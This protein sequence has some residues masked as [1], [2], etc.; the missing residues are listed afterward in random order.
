M[1]RYFF[2][3]IVLFFNTTQL[4]A[5]FVS[6]PNDAFKSFLMSKYPGCFNG[7]GDLDTT[8]AAIIT[9][10]SLV[11]HGVTGINNYTAL[12]Y[13]D[14]L[15]YLD[16][17]DN[18]FSAATV[19]PAKLPETITTLIA[20]NLY[21][22]SEN[23]NISYANSFIS[24]IPA[25][26]QHFGFSKNSFSE[27]NLV[28]WSASLRYLD[29][30]FNKFNG[31]AGVL[32]IS[33][34]T[35]LCNN[36]VRA[37][38][39]TVGSMSGFTSSL[40]VALKYFDCHENSMGS[41]PSLP[42][43]LRYIDCSSQ[44]LFFGLSSNVPV[45]ALGSLPVTLPA[46]LVALKCSKNKI[47]SLPV[48]PESL[49]YLDCSSQKY[50]NVLNSITFNYPGISSLPVLPQTLNYLNCGNNPISCLPTLP[51]SMTGNSVYNT[52]TYNLDITSTNI[53]C[54]PNW[55]PGIIVNG[56]L[57]MPLCGISSP[58]IE[59]SLIKGFIFNDNNSNGVQD[60]GETAGAHIRVKLNNDTYTFSNG[61]GKYE[62]A[63]PIGNNQVTIEPPFYYNAVPPTFTH[64][65]TNN[66]TI[67][68]D[69]VALQPTTLYDSIKVSIT[70][71]NN[72]RANGLLTY[73]VNFE[74]RGT[75]TVNSTITINF[76][77]T[78]LNYN[79][80]NNG[81]VIHSGNTLTLT[82]GNLVPGQQ[83]SFNSYFT[84]SILAPFSTAIT[85]IAHAVAGTCNDT[86]SSICYVV[87]AID[88][89]D[90]QATAILSGDEVSRGFFIDYLIR[91]QNVGNASA[92]N[93]FITDTLSAALN[94]S[95]MELV[96]TSYNCNMTLTDN[97]LLC[98]FTNINLPDS[99]SSPVGSHGFVKFRI[100]P[101]ATLTSNTIIKNKASIYF[102]YNLPV[103]TN[104]ANTIIAFWPIPLTLLDFFGQVDPLNNV[105]LTWKTAE[106]NNVSHFEIE[107]STDGRNFRY[108]ASEQAIGTGSNMYR[109]SLKLSAPVV[110]YRLKMV[111][112][113]GQSRYSP[114]IR[115]SENKSNTGLIILNNPVKNELNIRITDNTL[116]NTNAVLYNCQ[117]LT[118]KK[119][120]LIGNPV[121]FDLSGLCS[122][123]YYLKTA[124][125]TEKILVCR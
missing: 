104:T 35:L 49:E 69:V 86:D 10:D 89:N 57:N 121:K 64:T 66:S 81:S 11:F 108:A 107:E 48:L 22:V 99:T 120:L 103:V 116:I 91:F 117:G 118:V 74:N 106:E 17:S 20:N 73:F 30:S 84:V 105:L 82:T 45:P 23:I 39:T 78:L 71:S 111:D 9:E 43:T 27:F 19:L 58:C 113:D 94:I 77:N 24:R 109:K 79:S 62:F 56:N 85:G 125:G 115:L 47:T 29:I 54:L 119:F 13:F 28:P 122:G 46:S 75:T 1:K 12:S 93:V 68:N 16:C 4:K 33:L 123:V 42:S 25:N 41:L 50:Y 76:N 44:N 60:A 70:A 6:L 87:A 65:I 37:N 92:I 90:K 95:S 5:Q 14:A 36:Q 61:L 100:K 38:A 110:F 97:R 32:P 102:D 67:V 72:P 26:L 101:S 31:N 8:C 34:D 88:P 59:H 96:A 114:I 63:A 40:P 98:E 7:A 2:L 80:S 15:K 51:W 55:V 21:G 18:Y 124:Q 53:T 52:T 83:G 112:T 3:L